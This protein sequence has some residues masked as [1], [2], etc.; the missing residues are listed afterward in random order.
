MLSYGGFHDSSFKNECGNSLGGLFSPISLINNSFQGCILWRLYIW[1]YNLSLFERTGSCSS[2]GL[3][4]FQRFRPQ[5]IW[6]LWKSREWWF[7]LGHSRKVHCIYGPDWIKR[8]LRTAIWEQPWR[9]PGSLPTLWSHT[10]HQ[11]EW[12]N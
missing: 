10:C 7:E 4:R 1:V 3:V 8:T 2:F 11:T 6:V 5:R 9:L 12:T